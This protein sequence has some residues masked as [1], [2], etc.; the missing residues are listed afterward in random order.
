M[1]ESIG[2]NFTWMPWGTWSAFAQL[3]NLG[4]ISTP[5]TRTRECWAE[6]GGHVL[7]MDPSNCV[8]GAETE[9]ETQTFTSTVVH[10]EGELMGVLFEGKGK[11]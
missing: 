8:N 1:D 11:G 4:V 2:G 6:A 5:R 9:S 7:K 10:H 3:P